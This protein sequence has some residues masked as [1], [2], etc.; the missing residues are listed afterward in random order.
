MANTYSEW[1][2]TAG[3]IKSFG[4]QEVELGTEPRSRRITEETWELAEYDE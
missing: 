2:G 1:Y 4:H 3:M